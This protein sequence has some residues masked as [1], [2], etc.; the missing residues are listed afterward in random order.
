M[1]EFYEFSTLNMV[2][3]FFSTF[4]IYNILHK[5]LYKKPEND[6]KDLESKFNFEYLLVS[7]IISICISLIVSYILAEKS[8]SILTDNF[9]DP[10]NETSSNN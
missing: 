2:I 7:G 5:L 3:V 6:K 10:V 9:W 8:E 4:V 1:F